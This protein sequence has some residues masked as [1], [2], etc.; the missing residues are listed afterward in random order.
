MKDYFLTFFKILNLFQIFWIKLNR[1]SLETC[2]ICVKLSNPFYFESSV[3]FA[4]GRFQKLFRALRRYFA[5]CAQHFEKLWGANV[6]HR[7]QMIGA[8]RETVYEIG[9]SSAEVPKPQTT[10]P[11]MAAVKRLWKTH[12]KGCCEKTFVDL[13]VCFYFLSRWVHNFW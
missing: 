4:W 13:K 2:E 9:V 3:T 6:V 8:G 12:E 5:P 11:K 1:R 7:A 10:P